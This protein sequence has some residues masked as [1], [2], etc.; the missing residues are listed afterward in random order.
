MRCD[1]K[2][3]P[4]VWGTPAADQEAMREAYFTGDGF[5]PPCLKEGRQVPIEERFGESL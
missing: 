2:Y 3:R 1:V 5:C 4:I